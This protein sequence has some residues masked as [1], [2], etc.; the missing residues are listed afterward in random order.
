[1]T[2]LSPD[3]PPVDYF[4]KNISRPDGLSQWCGRCTEIH[5]RA[6][7]KVDIPAGHLCRQYKFEYDDEA[8]V[9][10]C[11][12]CKAPYSSTPDF[13]GGFGE[14]EDIPLLKLTPLEMWKPWKLEPYK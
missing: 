2:Y 9:W 5:A 6:H 7:R 11:P 10:R 3:K 14:D 8:R 13:G 12:M 1:M 4:Y